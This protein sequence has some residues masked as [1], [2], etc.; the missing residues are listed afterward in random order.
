M[1]K[2]PNYLCVFDLE[3]TDKIAETCQPIQMAFKMYDYYSL[4]EVPNGEFSTL[5]RP[6]EGTYFSPEA[7]AVHKIPMEAI[8][9]APN[10]KLAWQSFVE[11][12]QKYNP[13]KSKYNSPVVAGYNI[14]GYDLKI[15]DRLNKLCYG[16]KPPVLFNDF[17]GAVDLMKIIQLLFDTS[18][19]LGDVKFDTVRKYFG[20]SDSQAHLANMDI[21]H[22]GALLVRMLKFLRQT[23]RNST[24]KFKNA[25]KDFDF[26][27]VTY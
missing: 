18:G 25:F 15:V 20:I 12:V 9:K 22:E 27:T 24:R 19:E 1:A 2:L 10:I 8:Q 23:T 7:M 6:P 13:S 26:G 11:E 14:E 17:R 5:C 3:T 16:D 4:D 21:R